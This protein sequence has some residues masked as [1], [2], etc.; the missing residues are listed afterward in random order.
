MSQSSTSK[1]SKGRFIK[2][3]SHT[4]TTR[5]KL[6]EAA[7]KQ[8]AS[9]NH[10]MQGKKHS[11][12]TKKK[13][14][15]AWAKKKGEQRHRAKATQFKEGELP[16][17]REGCGCFR[18]N[19]KPLTAKQKKEISERNKRT[20]LR[21]PVTKGKD[22]PCWQGGISFGSYSEEF[23][24]ELKEFIRERDGY[25]CQR[26]GRSQEEEG[27]RLSVHHINHDKQDCSPE[28][29]VSTCRSCNSYF[30][31]HR[32]ES[33]LLFSRKVKIS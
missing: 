10:P 26:C 8:F 3:H 27:R 5:K 22:H 19:P 31:F 7:K 30:N 2:G 33:I 17:H 9:G 13:L 4:P 14:R 16:A 23:N 24:A 15:A 12:E 25:L 1:D 11:E 6:S 28:N 20:G 32:I 18:C 21:P 29:L